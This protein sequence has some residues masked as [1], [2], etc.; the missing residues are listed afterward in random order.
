MQLQSD[1]AARQ[2]EKNDGAIDVTVSHDSIDAPQGRDGECG[3]VQKAPA[4]NPSPH[5][6]QP[7]DPN[8]VVC[9]FAGQ[10][11]KSGAQH[12]WLMAEPDEFPGQEIGGIGRT[13]ANGR[14]FV[15]DQQQVHR[16]RPPNFHELPLR[17]I[18]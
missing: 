3:H 10:T 17:K 1:R 9:C 6:G 13:A 5:G 16:T 8:P 18:R 12:Q 7:D 2:G 14:I 11:C 4:I 15:I